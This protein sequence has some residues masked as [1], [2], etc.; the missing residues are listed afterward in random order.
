M[1]LIAILALAGFLSQ[2]ILHI[3][4]FV[5]RDPRD[6]MQPDWI[7]PLVSVLTLVGVIL[8]ANFTEHLRKLQAQRTGLQSPEDNPPW[9]K[10]ILWLFI[11]YALFNGIMALFVDLRHGEPIRQAPGVYVADTGH[12]RPPAPISEDQYHHIRQLQVRRGSGVF[13]MFYFAIASDLLFTVTGKKSFNPT[14]PRAGAFFVAVI[15]RRK[16]RM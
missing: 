15:R 3:A 10:P 7:F 6:W 1:W 11:A 5:S 13:M 16:W 4:S 9:S 12:G 14:T 2:V 8:L